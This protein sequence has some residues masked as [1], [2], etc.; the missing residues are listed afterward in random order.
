VSADIGEA[1]AHRLFVRFDQRQLIQT[2]GSIACARACTRRDKIV[3]GGARAPCIQILRGYLHR[4]RVQA[5]RA[6]SCHICITEVSSS[7]Q[8]INAASRIFNSV[9]VP[10]ISSSR[11]LR[12]ERR[13]HYL[14]EKLR[15]SLLIDD[16]PFANMPNHDPSSEKERKNAIELKSKLYYL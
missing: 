3:R 9:P 5:R 10:W 12:P 16:Q 14:A 8:L 6:S 2:N 1:S 13:F 15:D 11:F 4:A 7:V